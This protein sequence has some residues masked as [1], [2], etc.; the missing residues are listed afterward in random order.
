MKTIRLAYL[1]IPI[2][3]GKTIKRAV[4]FLFLCWLAFVVVLHP[5]ETLN[6]DKFYDE[7]PYNDFMALT[8][9]F[10]IRY[11]KGQGFTFRGHQVDPRP[12]LEGMKRS[13]YHWVKG[14]F[15]DIKE[16]PVSK[17]EVMSKLLT[18]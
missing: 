11:D 8:L 2:P 12:F 17:D 13:G 16:N 1:P 14:S 3:S 6:A 18:R 4:Y 7:I 15:R 10:D 9:G 5:K